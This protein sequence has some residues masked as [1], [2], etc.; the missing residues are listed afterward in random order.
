MNA[1]DPT[2]PARQEIVTHLRADTNVTTT[3]V[4]NRVYGERTPADKEWPFALYEADFGQTDG[5][6]RLHVFSKAKFS[7]QVAKIMAA[8][9]TSLGGK[10]LVMPDDRK[11]RLTYPEANGSQIL[12]D[13]AEANAW[14]GIVRFN[15]FI[16]LECEAA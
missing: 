11:L 6:V 7:D 8:M 10:T 1:I 2:L 5:T 12:P 16:V 13:G 15:A 3:D 4:G 9:V 14:H